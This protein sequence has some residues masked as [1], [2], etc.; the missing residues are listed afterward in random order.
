LQLFGPYHRLWTYPSANLRVT[1]SFEAL[2]GLSE[3]PSMIEEVIR[4]AL[5]DNCFAKA[6][7][8]RIEDIERPPRPDRR[9]P[10]KKRKLVRWGMREGGIENL[11]V[12]DFSVALR[13]GSGQARNP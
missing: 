12:E 10:E 7:K 3:L 1:D 6:L 11:A 4:S 2:E 5:E 13:A 8:I 9:P